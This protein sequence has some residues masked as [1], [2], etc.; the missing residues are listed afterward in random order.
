MPAKRYELIV[1][2]WDGTLLDSAGAIVRAIQAASRDLGL[3]VPEDARARHVIGLGLD[4]ALHYAVPELTKSRYP[5]MVARYRHHYLSRDQELVLF[6]GVASTIAHLAEQGWLLAVA[7]G[8]SRVGLDRALA[9]S[10]LGA[11]FHA[12]RCADECFS[13]PHPAMLEELM[14]ELSVAPDRTLMIG[15][16]TH[17]LQ[18]AQN[19]GVDG[20]AVSFGAHDVDALASV[21][22]VALLASPAELDQWLRQNA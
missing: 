8:K 5:E 9:H 13:K 22:S 21:P 11:H 19:A 7:T 3:P 20:L 18:M 17:D 1:F 6:D 10:G 16:T 4:D 15:D 12:T 2:D 14:S